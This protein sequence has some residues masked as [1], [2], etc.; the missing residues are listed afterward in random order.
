MM[1]AFTCEWRAAGGVRWL[2]W[3]GAGVEAAF[4]SREG[5]LSAGPYATLNLGLAVGDDA[6]AV[7]E[8]R[9]RLGAAIGLEGGRWVVPS[10][11]HGT[12]LV[13]VGE[14]EAGRGARDLTSTIAETDALLTAAPGVGLAVSH[15]DCVP[16]VIVADGAEGPVVA[17]A[18]AGWRGMLDGIVEEAGAAVARRARLLG[19]VV[20]PSIGPC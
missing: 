7:L 12:H 2:R 9:R 19:A 16:V 13:E 15:A 18:H 5:G 6:A 20:G 4:P 14:A 11:V 10:Q 8:N 1:S 17:A 3:G